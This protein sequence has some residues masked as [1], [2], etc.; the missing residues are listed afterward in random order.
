MP[1][2][3]WE[4]VNLQVWAFQRR[5]REGRGLLQ[6][7]PRWR[8]VRNVVRDFQGALKAVDLLPR[9]HG[10]CVRFTQTSSLS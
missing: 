3:P 8:G 10:D 1:V 5:S 9:V 6:T 4:F 2:D 7:M